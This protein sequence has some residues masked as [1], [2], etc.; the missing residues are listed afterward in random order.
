MRK[1]ALFVALGMWF[2]IGCNQHKIFAATP[3][4]TPAETLKTLTEKA[5]EKHVKFRIYC[6][7][8]TGCNAD[9]WNEITIE[10]DTSHASWV[11]H[12][13]NPQDAAIDLINVLKDKPNVDAATNT[14]PFSVPKQT[15]DSGELGG[16]PQPTGPN[17]VVIEPPTSG[18]FTITMPTYD[19]NPEVTKEERSEAS[20]ILHDTY[21]VFNEEY[22]EDKLPKDTIT[23]CT[24]ESIKTM[25][26][27]AQTMP[28]MNG[29]LRI[30]VAKEF[31]AGDKVYLPLL[32]HEMVHVELWGTNEDSPWNDTIHGK[33]FHK[34]MRR[35]ADAGAF[36]DLW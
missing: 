3:K 34:E 5:K 12:A 29:R 11:G 1:T 15:Y 19:I 27:Q 17:V 28:D 10:F 33:A 16:S 18:S 20:K 4:P 30:E 9:A 8:D 35:L 23:V 14:S 24:N 26:A 32:L 25:D 31:C 2:L 7:D 6:F 21:T 36:D 13:D 22:F